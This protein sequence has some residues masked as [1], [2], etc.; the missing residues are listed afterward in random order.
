MIHRTEGGP[1][2]LYRIS[3]AIHAGEKC[4]F[5]MLIGHKPVLAQFNASF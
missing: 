5:F 2:L 1:T 4:V 3:A